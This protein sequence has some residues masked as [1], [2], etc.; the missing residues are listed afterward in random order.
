MV[1]SSI[2]Q[3]MVEIQMRIGM[4]FPFVLKTCVAFKTLAEEFGSA[5]ADEKTPGFQ[6]LT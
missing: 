2:K 4:T 3:A 1:A 6:H 5:A